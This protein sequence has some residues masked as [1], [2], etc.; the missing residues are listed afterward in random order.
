M[1]G[2]SGW[3][4]TGAVSA[5][6][7]YRAIWRSHRNDNGEKKTMAKTAIVNPRAANGRFKRGKRRAK[8]KV[9]RHG[10]RRN[11]AP[12]SA[13]RNYNPRRRSRRR[14]LNPGA[15]ASSV[16]SAGGY[17]RK[18]NPS[19]LLDFDYLMDTMP[20]GTLGI[21]AVRWGLKMA[22]DFEDNKPGFKH[23]LAGLLAAS[24]G[25][26]AIGSML[27]E[28]K[29][30]IARIGGVSFLGD[31]FA[32]KSLFED[33]DWVKENL[34]LSGVD[35]LEEATEWDQDFAGFESTSALGDDGADEGSQ[36][37]VGPDGTVY[38]LSGV[39]PDAAQ[40][41]GGVGGFESTSQL[42]G[43]PSSES[44]FGYVR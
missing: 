28:D 35:E 9:R 41:P 40:L 43:M 42:G 15:P 16:Y 32:R 18:P 4:A 5:A 6:R 14:R 37:F 22:G 2:G 34:M 24:V 39:A 25:A 21:W 10:R 30:Q 33:S 44:S 13:D 27:G 8:S 29:T 31:L 19:D 36:M 3:K 1:I 26:N 17:R 20:A 7:R 11:P 12:A 38:Q 23:G